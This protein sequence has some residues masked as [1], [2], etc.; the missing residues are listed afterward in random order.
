MRNGRVMRAARRAPFGEAHPR[1]V[2][3]GR[4]R[5]DGHATLRHPHLGRVADDH[6]ERRRHERPAGFLLQ[7]LEPRRH[8]GAARGRRIG[9]GQ[10]QQ[11]A[12][13]HARL[14]AGR[15]RH[16]AAL[17]LRRQ[18][19]VAERERLAVHLPGGDRP[20]D[21]A[22]PL[23]GV[24]DAEAQSVLAGIDGDAA[25]VDGQPFVALERRQIPRIGV[26][27]NH[28]ALLGGHDQPGGEVQ[29]LGGAAFDFGGHQHADAR[30]ARLLVGPRRHAQR[31]RRWRARP[32]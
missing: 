23:V 11:R 7:H 28:L 8:L 3:A 18:Q 15:Q 21:A 10:G 14:D 27:R 30:R 25:D 16:H 17:G 13:V 9:F 24:G 20:L 4:D 1:Q 26:G 19:Q 2:G 12:V 5:R 29:R 31:Q 22:D 32:I 6:L